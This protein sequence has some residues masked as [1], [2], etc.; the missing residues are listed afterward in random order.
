MRPNKRKH[1]VRVLKEIEGLLKGTK[2]TRFVCGALATEEGKLERF[3]SILGFKK[4]E[5]HYYK[6]IGG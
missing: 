2:A 6:K 1:T 3:Y 4:L 5:T